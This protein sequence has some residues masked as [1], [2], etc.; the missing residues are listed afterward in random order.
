[1]E[2][3]FRIIDEE[4]F[5]RFCPDDFVSIGSSNMFP[6][7]DQLTNTS[8]LPPP[9][10]VTR[11]MVP[12]TIP[13][14]RPMVIP[15][16]IPNILRTP[17]V[18]KETKSSNSPKEVAAQKRKKAQESE[19]ERRNRMNDKLEDLRNV[20]VQITGQHTDMT[21]EQIVETATSTL[22]KLCEEINLLQ[23]ELQELKEP[24]MKKPRTTT[25]MTAL[26]RVGSKE[27]SAHGY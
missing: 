5:D 24:V 13:A 23:R 17:I 15:Q 11:F 10:P 22:I 9:K 26:K 1:M 21:K 14:K 6:W 3:F 19:R 16:V 4:K 27:S 12:N 7:E 8:Y 18:E 25:T 20:T 2:D